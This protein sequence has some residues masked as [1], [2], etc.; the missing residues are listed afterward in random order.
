MKQMPQT[1]LEQKCCYY[2]RDDVYADNKP[3]CM[4]CCWPF[5]FCDK[6][7]ANKE[8]RKVCFTGWLIDLLLTSLL[9][10]KHGSQKEKACTQKHQ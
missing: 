1:T 2:T 4:C 8:I 7:Q 9:P 5:W 3:V 10:Y 6:R